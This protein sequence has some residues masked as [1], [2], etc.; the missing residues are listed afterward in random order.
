[1][2]GM[3]FLQTFWALLHRLLRRNMADYTKANIAIPFTQTDKVIFAKPINK[4]VTN[5]IGITSFSFNTGDTLFQTDTYGLVP[6]GIFSYDGGTSYNSFTSTQS[7]PTTGSPLPVRVSVDHTAN[8]GD[9]RFKVNV[10]TTVGGGTTIPISIYVGL[11]EGINNNVS[12]FDGSTQYIQK[13]AYDSRT[14]VPRIA[15]SGSVLSNT[16]VNTI[17]H[18]FSTIPDVRLYIYDTSSGGSPTGSTETPSYSITGNW[19]LKIDAT[20]IYI[21]TVASTG[22]TYNY[23]VYYT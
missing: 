13:T 3:M 16:G 7:T 19:A 6:F 4:D 17:A 14:P 22:Y 9:I 5:A 1:M 12:I 10:T 8:N 11:I 15:L 20:N 21:L 18:G 2:R 23:E